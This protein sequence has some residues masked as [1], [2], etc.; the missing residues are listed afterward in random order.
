ML[1]SKKEPSL[2][3]QIDFEIPKREYVGMAGKT[4]VTVIPVFDHLFLSR[5]YRGQRENPCFGEK[6]IKLSWRFNRKGRID[7]VDFMLFSD[8]NPRHILVVNNYQRINS[9]W[10]SAE[11]IHYPLPQETSLLNPSF[12]SLT[13]ERKYEHILRYGHSTA[14][15]IV[16]CID[17]GNIA[18]SI[19][20]LES[21]QEK[22]LDIGADPTAI[23][24]LTRA[25]NLLPSIEAIP[26]I[27]N[28]RLFHIEY[29]V[30]VE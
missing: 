24:L 9:A 23:A 2:E 5:I 11:V 8:Y 4:K 17:T 30:N 25:G 12:K 19:G 27:K 15:H 28:R 26:G 14:K 29:D 1:E 10:P 18:E 22:L 3:E 7:L 21:G 16:E 20:K 6:A 13:F